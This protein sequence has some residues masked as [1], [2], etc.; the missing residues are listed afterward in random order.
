M[1]PSILHCRYKCAVRT[2]ESQ[3]GV[4]RSCRVDADQTRRVQAL[5]DDIDVAQLKVL[6]RDV[7]VALDNDGFGVRQI[8]EADVVPAR[9]EEAKSV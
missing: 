8:R 1:L 4:Q 3:F 5:W 2:R 9:L 7:G 6:A